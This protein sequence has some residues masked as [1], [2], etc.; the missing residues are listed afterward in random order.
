[1]PW[2][3]MLNQAVTKA[4]LGGVSQW[5]LRLWLW[6]AL[7]HQH[8]VQPGTECRQLYDGPS[9]FDSGLQH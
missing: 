1:M 9:Q 5:D 8:R 3:R 6:I 2:D 7:Q 4:I